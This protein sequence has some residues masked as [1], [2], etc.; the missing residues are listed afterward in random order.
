MHSIVLIIFDF[1][2]LVVL[3]VCITFISCVGITECKFL[4]VNSTSKR[5]V[6]FVPFAH[7][8]IQFAVLLGQSGLSTF[9]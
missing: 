8:C 6:L 4:P 9:I 2:R 1:C 7:W 3:F 5:D